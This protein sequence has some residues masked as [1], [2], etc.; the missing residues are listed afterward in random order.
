MTIRSEISKKKRKLQMIGYSGFAFFAIGLILSDKSGILPI[1]AFIGFAV[2]FVSMF[3]ALWGIC[4]PRC[5]GNF[6]YLAMYHGSPFAISKKIKYCP[7][8][9]VDV[10]TELR[11]EGEV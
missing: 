5:R 2:F 4:C 10:D 6:G 9:G 3:Y 1:F 8:C 11:K 7:F